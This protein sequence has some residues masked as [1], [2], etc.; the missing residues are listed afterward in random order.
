[1]CRQTVWGKKKTTK[2]AKKAVQNEMEIERTNERKMDSS[3]SVTNGIIDEKR[4]GSKFTE[5]SNYLVAQT[6][7]QPYIYYVY[8]CTNIIRRVLSIDKQRFSY[9][10]LDARLV[11]SSLIWPSRASPHLSLLSA[12]SGFRENT[13]LSVKPG[14]T[15]HPS[16]INM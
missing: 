2:R 13:L 11:S 8:V 10:V 5:I 9:R 14:P 15:G 1:M 4:W 12:R 16:L 6:F 3:R 7:D